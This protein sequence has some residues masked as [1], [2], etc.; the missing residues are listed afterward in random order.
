VRE[1]GSMHPSGGFAPATGE[2]L[3]GSVRTA[4]AFSRITWG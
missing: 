2:V 4:A 3:A 1:V